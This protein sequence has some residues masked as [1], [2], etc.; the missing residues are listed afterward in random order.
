MT[1]AK[2]LL[3]AIDYAIT[4]DQGAKYRTFLKQV[5]PHIGDAY[6]GEEKN[7]HRSHLGASVIGGSCARKIWMGFRWVY[8]H[9]KEPRLLRL[10]NRGHME[11]G[12]FIAMLLAAGIQVYQQDAQ[13]NQFR[14]SEFGGHFGGSGD[15]V[16][17]GVPGIPAGEYCLLEFKTHNDKSFSTLVKSG[18][19]EAKPEHYVQMLIYMRKMNLRYGV[20]L[21]VNKND[22]SLW[23]E[24]IELDEQ[25]AEGY[26]NRARTIIIATEPPARQ[27][28]AG[29]AS[30]KCKFCDMRQVCFDR[31]PPDRNCRSCRHC[32]PL[33]DGTWHCGHHS[34]IVPKDR[35]P[36][37]CP[38][39]DPFKFL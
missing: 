26:L 6:R 18:M 22:D 2:E 29:F 5:M 9:A 38:D 3:A 17:L 25:F 33:K 11:E 21:A 28:G 23:A 20:Y 34:I 35:L 4:V 39:H 31:E 36:E 15:G 24:I 27:P 14:I 12:R 7:P 30:F 10:F 19:R 8:H 16:A 32:L 1:E 37:A 13:G